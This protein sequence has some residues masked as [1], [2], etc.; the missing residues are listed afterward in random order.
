MPCSRRTRTSE[1][2]EEAW[3]LR[4]RARA[5]SLG[6]CTVRHRSEAPQGV[7]MVGPG[8]IAWLS[9]PSS[10]VS[11][12]SKA[13][14]ARSAFFLPC[15]LCCGLGDALRGLLCRGLLR[16]WL[17]D[18]RHG[19]TCAVSI[20][21]R[22]AAAACSRGLPLL[23][24]AVAPCSFSRCVSDPCSSCSRRSARDDRRGRG[25]GTGFADKL[26]GTRM[27]CSRRTRTSE[28]GETVW[29]LRVRACALSPGL[30]TVLHRSEAPQG[31]WVVGPSSVLSSSSSSSLEDHRLESRLLGCT[32]AASIHFDAAC[33]FLCDTRV[34]T[35]ARCSASRL[36]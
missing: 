5:L 19:S 16:C 28:S 7:G 17:G 8:S 22:A 2:G 10:E 25:S 27:P 32:C 26:V 33:A 29:R 11:S 24:P 30:C 36:L 6:L 21:V 14:H 20:H 15:V 18:A 4:V 13:A 31:V 23:R 1:S 34:C 9:S 12:C 3:R 35:V